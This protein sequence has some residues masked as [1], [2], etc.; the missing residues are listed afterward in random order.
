M[1]PPAGRRRPGR[2]AGRGRR[3]ARS[4]GVGQV[5]GAQPAADTGRSGC[6][7]GQRAE[8][9][10]DGRRAEPGRLEGH[11][12]EALGR[13]RVEHQR[14]RAAAASCAPRLV[15]SG[16]HVQ[17]A[18]SRPQRRAGSRRPG[19]SRGGPRRRPSPGRRRDARLAQQ[20]RRARIAR[21]PVL[22]AVVGAEHEHERP[23]GEAR[24]A[25]SSGGICAA[26]SPREVVG[27]VLDDEEPG[28]AR[29][30]PLVARSAPR[31][32]RGDHD[33][34][35]DV[36]ARPAGRWPGTRSQFRGR[37]RGRRRPRRR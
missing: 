16:Q 29:R 11:Q 27:A 7:L 14:R 12:A 1:S 34:A 22:V 36:A 6:D 35:V 15:T 18:S 31:R 25:S 19:S 5:G 13:G 30:Q 21:S 10:V 24:A 17:R 32:R 8:G 4:A 20:A 2:P 3:A 28:R 37:R 26:S 33:D 9:D 23:A